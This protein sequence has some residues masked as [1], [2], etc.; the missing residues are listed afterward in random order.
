MAA[1]TILGGRLDRHLDRY[2]GDA[3]SSAQ[4]RMAEP[5]T[6]REIVKA[7]FANVRNVQLDDVVDE[8][9]LALPLQ[10][11]AKL[12]GDFD[13]LVVINQSDLS[14]DGRFVR[15]LFREHD[16]LERHMLDALRAGDE[17]PVPEIDA[18]LHGDPPAAI[19]QASKV[20]GVE[21][22][23][24]M[25][26]HDLGLD[27]VGCDHALQQV[28]NGLGWTSPLTG[29]CVSHQRESDEEATGDRSG[30]RSRDRF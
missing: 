13:R 25:L 18:A 15:S 19:D 7:Q 27:A 23:G 20:I 2:S 3:G 14:L 30:K 24:G 21:A 12:P 16:A 6:M 9:G 10:G 22:S 17:F 8:P 4:L 1:A 5:V 28:T 29:T 26:R 11:K